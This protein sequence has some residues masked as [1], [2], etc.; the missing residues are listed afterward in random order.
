MSTTDEPS[1]A[2]DTDAAWAA[3][4]LSQLLYFRSLSLRQKLEAV[5]EMADVAR[6]FREMREQKRFVEPL[7]RRADRWA[8]SLP[9]VDPRSPDSPASKYPA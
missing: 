9:A 7:M 2:P 6:R 1:R 3:N 4:N 5:Q 8:N